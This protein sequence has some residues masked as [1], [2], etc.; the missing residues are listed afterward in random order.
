VSEL[1]CSV[2][3]RREGRKGRGGGKRKKKENGKRKKEKEKKREGERERERETAEIA[4]ATAAGRARAPVRRDARDESEQGDGTAM[5]PDVGTVF[6][7][8]REIGRERSEL[9]DD[10]YLKIYF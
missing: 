7:G 3:E 1:L 5:D 6:L 8:D 4:A 9:N 10:R 2:R